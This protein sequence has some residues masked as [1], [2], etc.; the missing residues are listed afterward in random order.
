VTLL[1]ALT[2]VTTERSLRVATERLAAAGASVGGV[3]FNDRFN[4]T[5]GDE[6]CRQLDRFVRLAPRT[7]GRL[8]RWI[9]RSAILNLQ[10]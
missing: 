1:V 3:V 4:P 8:R 7:T 10:A 9:E 2:A 5:L 6:L